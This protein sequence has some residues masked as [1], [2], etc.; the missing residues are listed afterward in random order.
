MIKLLQEEQVFS[1]KM[2]KKKSTHTKR[3]REKIQARQLAHSITKL[4][5][6]PLNPKRLYD[7]QAAFAASVAVATEILHRQLLNNSLILIILH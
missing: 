5:K 2:N 1:I 4:M 6:N 3:E 7:L